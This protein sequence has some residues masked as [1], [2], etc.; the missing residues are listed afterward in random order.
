V[1][2][3][4]STASPAPPA[5]PAPSAPAPVRARPRLLLVVLALVVLPMVASAGVLVLGVGDRY[6]PVADLAL[7]EMQVRDVGREWVPSG[8]YSR[9]DWS[10]PGPAQFFVLAPFYWLSGGS[11]VGTFLGA[12]AVN[13]A[14][15]AGMVVVAWRRGGPALMLITALAAS[16]LVRTLGADFVRDPWNC[17][18]TVLPYG[19]V[20]FLVWALTRGDVWALPVAVGVTTYVAQAHVG[21]VVL[22]VPLLAFGALWCVLR[23]RRH[24]AEGERRALARAGAVAAGVGAVLW[25]PPVLDVLISAPSNLGNVARYFQDGE[26]EA[27]TLVDGWN[28]LTAQLSAV[29][30]WLTWHRRPTWF[31]GEPPALYEPLVPWL[32]APLALAG[33]VLWRRRHA[34][35]TLALTLAVTGGLGILAISRIIGPVFDYR[36][37]WTWIPGMVAFVVVAAAAWSLVT[38]RWDRAGR[39]LGPTALV[40]LVVLSGINTVDA[41][42][43]GTPFEGDSEVLAALLPGMLDAVEGVDGEVLV[44]D[45]LLGSWYAR[46]VVS[47]LERHG[48]DARVPEIRQELF[49]PS[50]VVGPAP[51]ARLHVAVN[52]EVGELADDPSLRLVA[53]WTALSDDEIEDL[54]RRRARLDADLAAERIDPYAHARLNHRMA[55]EVHSETGTFGYA[56][57]VYLDTG[58]P[59]GAA[60]GSGEGDR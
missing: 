12:L 34:A 10:H 31:S 15:V 52:Q 13:A 26:G 35:A 23:V 44:T 14:A 37:R 57:A 17:F 18:M 39:V 50:R 40:A 28:V 22:A 5:P 7:I 4:T 1:P 30:E 55:E 2:S 21:Y 8:L 33:V 45:T 54:H 46:G 56:V 3:A 58:L 9:E 48:S 24:G 19:L 59:A 51:A 47:E 11:P 42:R 41:L 60:R 53:R 16:L 36:L 6:V 27:R 29:P 25:L 20:V 43:S 32:L 49:G 38:S